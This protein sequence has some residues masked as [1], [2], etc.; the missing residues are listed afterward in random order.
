MGDARQPALPS[1]CMPRHHLGS[2][3]PVIFRLSSCTQHM[4]SRR[5]GLR[6]SGVPSVALPTAYSLPPAALHAKWFPPHIFTSRSRPFSTSAA[7]ASSISFCRLSCERAMRSQ[8][9]TGGVAANA[10]AMPISGPGG[11]GSNDPASIPVSLTA[12]A[13]SRVANRSSG[14]AAGGWL[15]CRRCRPNG[16]APACRQPAA[17]ATGGRQ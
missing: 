4:G 15:P 7:A 13:A 12:L 2:D 8:K 17:A 1:Q 14:T 3:C 5:D 10:A 16:A 9:S 6:A 11:R